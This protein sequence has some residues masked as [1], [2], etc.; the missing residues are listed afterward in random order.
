MDRPF[1]ILLLAGTTEARE[2]AGLLA[3]DA[4]LRVIASLA[5][6]TTRP[7]PLAVET[8][9]GGF[10]GA[11][12]LAAFLRQQTIDAVIDAS[13]PFATRISTNAGAACR[14]TGT[15]YMRLE[16]PAWQPGPGDDWRAVASLEE[17]AGLLPAGARVFLGIGRQEIGVFA[18]RRDVRFVMRMIDP[19]A[20]DA[21]R[22]P[23]EIVLGRPGADVE[24][25][26][27][28]LRRHAITHMVA[29]NS[30]GDA[31]RAKLDA[32]RGLGLPVFMVERPPVSDRAAGGVSA[33]QT[34][35]S[36]A[37]A[38]CSIETWLSDGQDVP[39]RPC[40]VP[41]AP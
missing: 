8:R 13:H 26:A 2:L 27:R 34:V 39:S 1:T 41:P 24:A 22:P 10:G 11:S 9:S 14:E 25:E 33:G 6:V 15:R 30:G 31:G 3:P 35:T 5:G 37:E 19:P 16:R 32:A 40:R 23:G 12:G 38:V 36:A 21:A 28:M 20:P 7:L 29:K 18:H 4:R 17:A